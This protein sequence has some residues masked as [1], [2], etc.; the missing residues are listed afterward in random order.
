NAEIQLIGSSEI[1]RKLREEV[2]VIGATD[3]TVLIEGETGVGKEVA[4]RAI[5]AHSQRAERPFIAINCAAIPRALF[6]SELFGHKKGAFTGADSDQPGKFRLAHGG[7]LFLDEV[8]EIPREIQSK[9]LRV[10]EEK[11]FYPLG[12]NTLVHVDV[13][14]ICATNADLSKLVEEGKFRRDLYFRLN[15]YTLKIPPLRERPEDILSLTK[16]FI[17]MYNLK[18]SKSVRSLTPEAKALLLEL[19]WKG[20]IRELRNTIERAVL[21]AKGKQIRKE[22][23]AFV[24]AHQPVRRPAS[25]FELPEEGID[26][27]EL[28]KNLIKQALEMAKYNKTRAARLLNISPPTLYY[29]LQKYGL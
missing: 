1:V 27:E 6:E 22:D 29:R 20:N 23:L 3:V 8:G 26:L 10:L 17:K 9:L 24:E 25:V 21:F 15:V 28:E 7:T 2:K 5:H 13:R 18:F 14:I 12:S 11:T 4:A 16:Y 19:P